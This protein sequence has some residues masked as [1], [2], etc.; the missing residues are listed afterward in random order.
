MLI[1]RVQ[2]QAMSLPNT[3][4]SV[5]CFAWMD[6]YFNLVSDD[7]PNLD[8]KHLEPITIQEIHSEY[9]ADMKHS[10]RPYFSVQAFGEFWIKIFPHVRIRQFKAVS[11]K[12]LTCAK[13]A[14]TRKLYRL[15]NEEIT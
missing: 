10:E 4:S 11:G 12:C 3:Q 1:L 6:T 7:M 5:D 15:V 8:E 2:V 9:V 14:H 13:L